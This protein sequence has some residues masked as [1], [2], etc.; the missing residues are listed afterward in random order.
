MKKITRRKGLK[1]LYKRKVEGSS[2][3]I[4]RRNKELSYWKGEGEK[5]K[6]E[7]NKWTKEKIEGG[8]ERE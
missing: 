5:C 2:S 6:I 4:S 8:G 1:R 7:S 3:N